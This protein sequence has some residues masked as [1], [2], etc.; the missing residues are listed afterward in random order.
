[1]QTENHPDSVMAIAAK[2]GPPI[3]VSLASLAGADISTIILW[4]T[5]IYTILMITHKLYQM[6]K[7]FRGQPR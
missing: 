6:Y 5:L 7:D 2:A 1:M 4:L 3:S